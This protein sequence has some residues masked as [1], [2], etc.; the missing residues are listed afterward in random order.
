M[1]P[2]AVEKKNN[3]KI[4]PCGLCGKIKKLREKT[5]CCGNWVCGSE[6]DYV[7][8]SYSRDICSRN[9]RRFTLCGS[10]HAEEHKGDWKTCKKCRDD[11]EPEMYVWYG[12]NEYN[13]ERLPNPPAFEPTYCAKCKEKISLSD[14]GYSNLCGVYRC[15]NCPITEKEREEIIR[16]Y[17]NKPR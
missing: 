8:F 6:N 5:D 1:T 17:K 14:G 16:E 11:F 15:D 2:K 9:H 10:H 12:T 4:P 3:L 7:L 13:F